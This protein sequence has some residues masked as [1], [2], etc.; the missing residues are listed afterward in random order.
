MPT[1]AELLYARDRVVAGVEKLRFFPL[2]VERGEGSWLVEP[3]GRRL[4]DMSATWTA[5]GLGHGHPAVKA[6]L[7]RAASD[8][9]GAGALSAVHEDAVALAEELLERTP[10]QSDRRVYFGH[11]G[12]DANDVAIRCAVHATGR[13][14][15]LAFERSYHGGIGIAMKASGVHVEAGSV[16]PD[17]QIVFTPYPDSYREPDKYADTLTALDDALSAKDVACLLLEPILSDGGLIVPPDG[18]LAEVAMRCAAHDTLLICDEVKMGLGR[19][20]TLHAFEHDS[21]TP[22]I[23][24]FGKSLGAGVPISAAVGPAAVLDEPGAS[25]LLTTA[26]NP[27][28]TAVA[29]AVLATIDD[30]GLVERAAETGRRL[31]DGLRQATAHLDAVGDVRGRGLA[32]GI[33]LVTDRESRN[34]DPALAAR[35][36][37][38]VWE[39]GGVVY[40]VGGNVLEVTPPLTLTDE[41]VDRAVELL[42]RGIEEAAA[43]KVSDEQVAAF[44]GW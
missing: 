21:I 42:A 26:G 38:R 44:A 3:G 32:I 33:D 8:P 25:A 35:T 13:E 34:R 31:R 15:V 17:K 22:D 37:Y 40:Y 29:R 9:P 23:V 36:V 19:P 18:F 30:E 43:G 12:S 28:S 7:I 1:A 16:A 39:L 24:T 6:A 2:A 41:D 4:L 11:A 5:S 14:R 27:F 20:G 10:G